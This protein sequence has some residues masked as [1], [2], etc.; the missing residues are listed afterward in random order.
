[1][2]LELFLRYGGPTATLVGPVI[3]S[4]AV[5][6]EARSGRAHALNMTD[7]KLEAVQSQITEP[8]ADIQDL[9]AEVQDLGAEMQATQSMILEKVSTL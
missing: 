7:L 4:G 1:M 8:K 5:I 2:L 3:G 6:T 9:G